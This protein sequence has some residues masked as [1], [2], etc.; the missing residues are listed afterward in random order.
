MNIL[1]TAFLH[2]VKNIENAGLYTYIY[3]YIYIHIYIYMQRER[4]RGIYR[5]TIHTRSTVSPSRN[6]Y[7]TSNTC[8][9]LAKEKG[10]RGKRQREKEEREKEKERERRK[11]DSKGETERRFKYWKSSNLTHRLQE[12]KGSYA[13]VTEGR[14]HLQSD[15]RRGTRDPR[16]KKQ[17]KQTS[18]KWRL[19]SDDGGDL[20]NGAH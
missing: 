12:K 9:L 14:R 20:H 15:Q 4:E 16:Q 6:S 8:G 19:L 17:I 18:A 7:K 13:S 5:P 3:I 1:R 2:F 10:E 11:R